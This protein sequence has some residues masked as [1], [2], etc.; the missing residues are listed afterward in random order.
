MNY[1]RARQDSDRPAAKGKAKAPSYSSEP[2]NP[3]HKRPK[4][5]PA[6]RHAS[7]IYHVLDI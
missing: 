6:E 3:P 7:S 2:W 1:T 5:H 4:R